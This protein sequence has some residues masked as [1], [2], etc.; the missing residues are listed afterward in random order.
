[1]DDVDSLIEQIVILKNTILIEDAKRDYKLYFIEKALLL[2]CKTLEK[3]GG[4]VW[5]HTESVK[6]IYKI[7]R[8]LFMG[9]ASGSIWHFRS[10]D[11]LPVFI[12]PV[13]RVTQFCGRI[14]RVPCSSGCQQSGAITILPA[15][16]LSHAPHQLKVLFAIM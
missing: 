9:K 6:R 2:T 5:Q 7:Y 12:M 11:H 16:G 3:G 1:M 13:S 10:L 15:K 8:D 4:S 14:S